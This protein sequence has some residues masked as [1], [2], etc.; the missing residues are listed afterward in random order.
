MTSGQGGQIKFGRICLV[1]RH[2]VICD[3]W[4]GPLF[5]DVVV[6]VH[7]MVADKMVLSK[8]VQVEAFHLQQQIYIKKLLL[9][10]P[11]DAFV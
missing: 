2:D 5:V 10:W 4:S 11:D 3:L 6:I 8:V 7:K 1:S 9:E